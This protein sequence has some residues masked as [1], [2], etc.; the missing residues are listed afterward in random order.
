MKPATNILDAIRNCAPDEP[1]QPGDK[2]W[3]DFSSVRGLALEKR[4]SRRLESY[5]KGGRFAYLA[6]AGHRGCGKSTEL[7]RVKKWAEDHGYLAIYTRVNE[8]LDP[9]DVDYPDLLLLISRVIEAEFR[10]RGT[11][12]TPCPSP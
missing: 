7:Y 6:L 9:Y 5:A 2:R 4:M 12:S 8:E 1:L 10:R 11:S 3:Q